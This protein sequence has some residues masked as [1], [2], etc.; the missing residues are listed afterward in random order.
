MPL[1]HVADGRLVFGDF[2]QGGGHRFF[3]AEG[4]L[5]GHE[6]PVAEVFR[7][8]AAGEHQHDR[9]VRRAVTAG[10][11][12]EEGRVATVAGLLDGEP[13]A[14]LAAGLDD[15]GVE[16]LVQAGAQVTGFIGLLARH[17]D[18]ADPAAGAAG[19]HRAAS[20]RGA[21]GLDR[22]RG[23]R[24]AA[25][26]GDV[27]ADAEFGQRGQRVH[28]HR[29][30]DRQQRLREAVQPPDGPDGAEVVARGAHVIPGPPR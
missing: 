14:A 7:P 30:G 1:G 26:G 4:A 29:E 11:F 5:L 19:T 16:E 24:V 9:G 10:E 13:A 27:V 3:A 23:E 12:G 17:H 22:F 20:A 6:V 28:R 15:V 25:V 2:D 18:G 21:H 8:P